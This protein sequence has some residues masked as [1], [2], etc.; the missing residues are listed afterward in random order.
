M[1]YYEHMVSR[2]LPFR[3]RLL[4]TPSVSNGKID[5]FLNLK[6]LEEFN[7][8]S[9]TNKVKEICAENDLLAKKGGSIV[10]EL[11]QLDLLLILP[12]QELPMHLN[13]P[14]FWGADRSTLPQWLLVAMKNSHLFEDIFIPQ[15]L[16]SQSF[17]IIYKL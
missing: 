1:E 14:Y 6:K 4:Q 10:D 8:P 17:N 16:F 12:G 2:I 3:R 7:S 13:V 15:V 9:F 11:F 5:P